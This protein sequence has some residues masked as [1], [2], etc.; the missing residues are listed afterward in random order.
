MK[1]VIAGAGA[2]GFNLARE[3]SN[4]KHDISVIESDGVLIRDLRERLDVHALAGNCT[5]VEQLRAANVET[6]DIFIAVTNSDEVNIVACTLAHALG[7]KRRIARIR[8]PHLSGHDALINKRDY[9]INRVVNPDVLAAET[10]VRLIETPGVTFQAQFAQGEVLLRAFRLGVNSGID[11]KP[12][13]ELGESFPDR[14]F[15]V[16]AIERNGKVRIPRGQD[17]LLPDDNVYLLM[18]KSSEDRFSELIQS[19]GS[20]VIGRV[21]VYGASAIGLDVLRQLDGASSR[22]LLEDQREVAEMAE[23]ALSDVLVLHGWV[24]E[25]EIAREVDFKNV[26]CFVAAGEDD[27]M[28]LVA[29]LYAKQ[30]GAKRT[31]VLAREPDVV[32]LL[33]ALEFDAVINAR[34]LAV[35]EI[36]RFVRPGKVLS[37]QRIGEGGAEAV[38][39]LVRKGSKAAEKSLMNLRLP[40]GAIVGAVFRDGSAFLPTGETVLEIG[41]DIVAFVLGDVRESVEKMFAGSRKIRF[42]SK[43]S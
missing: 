33:Q 29:A 4:D 9:H 8:N 13:S 5:D 41:D 24:S 23:A 31:M 32:P 18:L 36:S 1:I 28:N 25:D 16:A 7:S 12:L 15:L 17:V 38:E 22:V 35:S 11:N 14:P 34:L 43:S 30:K 40:G 21:V 37:V 19:E 20:G 39:L 26:D 2:V 27:R 42:E 3:L 6:A 10:A